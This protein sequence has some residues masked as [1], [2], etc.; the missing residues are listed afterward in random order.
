MAEPA[1]FDV[2]GNRRD[3][4]WLKGKYK[5]EFLDAGNVQKFA[6][7]RIDEQRDLVS[8]FVTVLNES[9]APQVLQ[10][11]ANHWPDPGL[12]DLTQDP[13]LKTLWKHRANVVHTDVR[14]V[15]EWNFG[16]GS[17]IKE[18]GGPHWLWVLSL[19]FP[20]DGL[21]QVGW[22]GSTNHW[23]PLRLTFQITKPVGGLRALWRHLL[24]WFRRLLG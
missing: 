13:R 20:S 10:P 19:T 7:V 15:A 17:V 2:Q 3:M 21:A 1:V 9:G 24:A 22:L 4:A 12:T 11:V 5:C 18:Q 23:G 16:G 8:I 6:L 14:G